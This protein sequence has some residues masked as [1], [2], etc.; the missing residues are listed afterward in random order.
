VIVSDTLKSNA[1]RVL[2]IPA[3]ATLPEIH[4]AAARIRKLALLGLSNTTEIDI[5]FL[6]EKPCTEVA[7]RAAVG[8]LENPVQ[9]LHERLFWIQAPQEMQDMYES[10]IPSQLNQSGR[11]H[12]QAL[13]NLFVALE[14][15]LDDSGI[16]LWVSAIRAWNQV[17]NDDEYWSLCLMLEEKGNFEPPAFPSE[18]NALRDIAVGLAAEPLVIA[19]RNALAFGDSSTVHRILGAFTDLID[20]GPWAANAQF[21][22]VA[23]LCERFRGSCQSI[24]QE[25]DSKIIRRSGAGETNKLFCDVELEQFRSGIKPDLDRIVQLLQPGDP[26][27]QESREQAALC[28]AGIASDYTWADDFI[29][30]EK[31]HE[32]ALSLAKD[33][34]GVIRIE[35]GLKEVRKAVHQQHVFGNLKPL[36]AA[37]SLKTINGFGVT[38][39]GRSDYDADTQSYATTRYFVA[40]FIPIFP[41]GRYRVI[42]TGNQYTFMGKLPFR[43]AERFHLGLSLT[44]IG[45]LII[46]GITQANVTAS[47]NTVS[48]STVTSSTSDAPSPQSPRLNEIKAQIESGRSRIASLEVQLKPVLDEINS[49]NARMDSLKSDLKSLD[50]QHNSGIDIDVDDYN[51][52]VDTYNTLLAQYRQLLSANSTDIKTHDDL[53]AED[54]VLVKQ[55][56]LLLQGGTQ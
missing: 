35:T 28:L 4:K 48:P 23:P 43:K 2:G 22:I 8:R 38:M 50:A 14:A 45:A 16:A 17:I 3:C 21:D 54:P 15:D 39:Y 11:N 12:D 46:L 55:Y 6:G 37:P 33:T 19:A 44:L 26:L 34:L 10:A 41:L 52:K 49:L 53:V 7:I 27:A 36:V 51:A 24:R 56:N 1:F 18:V 29:L 9:R 47:G 42:R 40:L 25:F 30:S 32:E 13:R 31:L 5:P 20:T